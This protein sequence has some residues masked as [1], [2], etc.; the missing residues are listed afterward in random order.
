MMIIEKMTSS[1]TPL[2]G[3]LK[4]PRAMTSEL[5]ITTNPNKTKAP[6][7]FETTAIAATN[8]RIES[9]IR[10]IMASNLGWFEEVRES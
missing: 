6:A 3:E 5:V 9:T 1:T 8:L 2:M 10:E 7:T 4:R